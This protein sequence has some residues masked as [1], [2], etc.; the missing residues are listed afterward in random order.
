[1]NAKICKKLMVMVIGLNL[2]GAGIL[3]GVILQIYQRKTHDF[4]VKEIIHPG[5]EDG[6][7]RQDA[8]GPLPLATNISGGMSKAPIYH[9]LTISA[10]AGGFLIVFVTI[11]TCLMSRREAGAEDPVPAEEGDKIGSIKQITANINDLNKEI[12][13]QTES[14]TQSALVI[15]QMLSNLRSVAQTLNHAGAKVLF[16]RSQGESRNRTTLA[17]QVQ[18]EYGD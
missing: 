2:A 16:D 3:G 5:E 8:S 18:D 15:E 7:I 6:I 4:V 11:I 12:D 17:K 13:H 1:M 14:I 10:A 9:L